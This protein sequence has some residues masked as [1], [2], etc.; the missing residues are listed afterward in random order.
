MRYL[1]LLYNNTK[2]TY[3]GLSC[4]A[5]IAIFCAPLCSSE[6]R[7]Y[8]LWHLAPHPQ[9]ARDKVA[10]VLTLQEWHSSN[11]Q[12]AAEVAGRKGD[13]LKSDFSVYF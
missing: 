8:S 9:T 6:A 5:T 3:L 12:P 10:F 4:F 7:N 11:F 2:F 13:T 1:G